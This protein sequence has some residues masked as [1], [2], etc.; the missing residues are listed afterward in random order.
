MLV[1]RRARRRGL[2]AALMEAI[3]EVAR[4]EGRTLLV[5]DTLTGSAADRLYTRLRLAAGRRDPRL[6]AVPDGRPCPSTFFYR[7]VAR[8]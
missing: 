6:R 7:R 8:T 2:G 4:E 3:V 1:H 5:L